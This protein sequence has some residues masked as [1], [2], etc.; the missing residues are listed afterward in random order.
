M[1]AT[2]ENIGTTY[3]VRLHTYNWIRHYGGREVKTYNYIAAA[4]LIGIQRDGTYLVALNEDV[5]DFAGKV[6]YKK[7][8]KIAIIN[9]DF[10]I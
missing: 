7:G 2:I 6:A 10:D 3:K 4:K 5:I 8:H 1:K 9:I